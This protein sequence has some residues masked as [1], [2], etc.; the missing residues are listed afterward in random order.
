MDLQ[1]L[2]STLHVIRRKLL[3]ALIC[4]LN[5]V[6]EGHGRLILHLLMT[7]GAEGLGKTLVYGTGPVLS[8]VRVHAMLLKGIRHTQFV[9]TCSGWDWASVFSRRADGRDCEQ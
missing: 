1:I 5:K 2:G 7:T 9:P 8:V 4:C 3:S 6:S